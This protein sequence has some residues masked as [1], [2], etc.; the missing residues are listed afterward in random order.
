M[1]VDL[2]DNFIIIIINDNNIRCEREFFASC[3]RN[4]SGDR[5]GCISTFLPNTTNKKGVL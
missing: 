2:V 4:G 5:G 3:W 1:E